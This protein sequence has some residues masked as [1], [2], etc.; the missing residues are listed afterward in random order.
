MNTRHRSFTVVLDADT[1]Q[2][3]KNLHR[4][5]GESYAN[6]LRAAVH[7]VLDGLEADPLRADKSERQRV[8]MVEAVRQI[9][10]EGKDL[11]LRRYR[12]YRKR[13][14]MRKKAT[15]HASSRSV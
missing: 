6:L 5:S 12:M 10:A 11:R 8:T 14:K 7:V 4:Q 2:R 3:L 15:A 9:V 1:A 13:W